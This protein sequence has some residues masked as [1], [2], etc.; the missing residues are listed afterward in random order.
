MIE[1]NGQELWVCTKCNL[2]KPAS[3]FYKNSGST[4]GLS[5]WCKDCMNTNQR[6]WSKANQVKLEREEF[7][8]GQLE[9]LQEKYD[10]LEAKY[11]LTRREYTN[12]VVRLRKH[13]PDFDPPI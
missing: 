9:E 6:E 5:S 12:L 4:S 2:A 13:E 3:S 1:P 7:M 11:V 10:D 8:Q